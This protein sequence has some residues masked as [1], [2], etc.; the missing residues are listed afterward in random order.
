MLEELRLR[1]LGVLEDASLELGPG[2]IAITGETGAGKT[3]LLTGLGLLLGARADPALVRAGRTRA[4]VE[5]RW[6]V[7]PAGSVA[8]RASDAGGRLDDDAL[9]VSRSV[10]PE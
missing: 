3:M 4:D 8:A 6:R 7:A 5:G 2:F 10:S 9:I 1:G